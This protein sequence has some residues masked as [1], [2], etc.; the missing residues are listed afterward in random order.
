MIARV[1]NRI[2]TQKRANDT[3]FVAVAMSSASFSSEHA[4]VSGPLRYRNRER[5]F[6]SSCQIFCHVIY[7]SNHIELY[8]T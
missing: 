5:A 4:S 2:R 6:S 8:A 7:F 3:S 1:P